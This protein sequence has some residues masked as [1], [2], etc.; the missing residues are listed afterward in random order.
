MR[1]I[2]LVISVL[3]L[4]ACSQGSNN[5]VNFDPQDGE[6]RRYQIHSNL[7]IEDETSSGRNSDRVITEMVVDYQVSRDRSSLAIDMLPR[8]MKFETRNMNFA[9]FDKPDGY[10]DDLRELMDAGFNIKLDPET[11]D[12]LEFSANSGELPD[13]MQDPLFGVFRDE[14][15]RPGVAQGMRLEVGEQQEFAV[16]PD[17][18]KVTITLVALSDDEVTLEVEGERESHKLFGVIVLERNSGWV[19]R[20]A[21]VTDLVMNE[22]GQEFKVRTVSSFYPEDWPY[23]MDLEFME[24]AGEMLM[25]EMSVF[26]SR[27]ALASV[28]EEDVFPSDSGS[29]ELYRHRLSLSYFHNTSNFDALG[30]V[31]IRDAHAVDANGER[32]DL[33]LVLTESFAFNYG[34]EGSVQT[35]AEVLPLGW[36]RSYEQLESAAYI[37]ASLD[38]YPHAIEAVRMPINAEG[39][40]VTFGDARAELIPTDKPE[41]FE[42]FI[43][44]T[45]RY[46]FSTYVGNATDVMFT[47]SRY[48]NAPEWVGLGES[49]IISVT[50]KGL[51]PIHLLVYFEEG[52]GDYIELIGAEVQQDPES[53]RMV[54]FYDQETLAANHNLRPANEI[55]LYQADDSSSLFN[56]NS[57][58]LDFQTYP[59]GEIELQSFGRPQ[60][61]MT[62]TPEQA[63]LCEIESGSELITW[64]DKKKRSSYSALILEDPVVLQAQSPDGERTFFYDTTLTTKLVCSSNSQWREVSRPQTD[65][66]WL[67][68]IQDLPE[69][70][71][72]WPISLFLRR[73]QFLTQQDVALTLLPPEDKNTHHNATDTLADYLIEDRYLRVAGVPE[74]IMALEISEE[75]VKQ[76]LQH[77]FPSLPSLA[78]SYEEENQ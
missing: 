33:P 72:Q 44:N 31:R 10:D 75:T 38:W 42:L 1:K 13:D 40:S 3:L 24:Q 37:E 69:V 43:N 50:E 76:V 59:T 21:F 73:V 49:R 68:D 65:T 47:Y 57:D 34:K 52:P 56:F 5:T 22:Y 6:S 32:I 70:D 4:T 28:T 61:Y 41:V 7:R 9:S 14:L 25:D 64:A 71:L 12:I 11:G 63:A 53:S 19:S 35:T 29:I 45:D 16:D 20:G 48:E 26:D 54:K 78:A 46:Q 60:L 30:D 58:Q 23:G 66:P 27:K 36:Q 17:D 67:V 18:F 55:A 39:G 15:I 62:L 2:T 74:R 8:L 51:F 77:S